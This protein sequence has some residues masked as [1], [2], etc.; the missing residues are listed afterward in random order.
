MDHKPFT[1]WSSS[2]ITTISKVIDP[3]QG[4]FRPFS[5]LTKQY[6]L[7]PSQVFHYHQLTS[8][9]RSCFRTRQNPCQ[10]TF[11]DALIDWDQY[12]ISDIYSNLITHQ[13]TKYHIVPFKPWISILDDQDA[14]EKILAGY[15]K[16]RSLVTCETWLETQ[17]KIAHRVYLP[18]RNSKNDSK[19]IPVSQ[20]MDL[21]SS[22]HLLGPGV[23]LY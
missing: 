5:E 18:F 9:L 1:Q 19:T 2:G 16:I 11:I 8:Y 10:C 23:G 20:I 6:S 17:F 3:A 13:A 7:T 22:L 14:P 21:S 15:Q 12:S 4:T